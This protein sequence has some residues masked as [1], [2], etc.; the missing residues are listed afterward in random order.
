M[1]AQVLKAADRLSLSPSVSSGAIQR[2]LDADP[3]DAVA[4]YLALAEVHVGRVG[5]TRNAHEDPEALA[6]HEA[7]TKMGLFSTAQANV[8]PRWCA[9]T[10]PAR[11]PVELLMPEDIITTTCEFIAL[12]AYLVET[13]MFPRPRRDADLG[14]IQMGAVLGPISPAARELYF[15][16]PDP[17]L[18]KAHKELVE[19][20]AADPK[21]L[22]QRRNHPVKD[23]MLLRLREVG[24]GFDTA[25]KILVCEQVDLEQGKGGQRPTERFVAELVLLLDRR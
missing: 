24:F 16:G 11:L 22:Y 3:S 6:L 15:D 19:A 5:S 13:G 18:I 12:L 21:L 17:R 25:R 4:A 2:V 20:V 9:A 14:A 23:R 7:V 10:I 1:E 8:L